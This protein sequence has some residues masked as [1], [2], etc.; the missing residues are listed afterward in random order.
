MRKA[1]SMKYIHLNKRLFS[2]VLICALFLA[3]FCVS[4]APGDLENANNQ[5]D[6]LQDQIDDAKDELDS[7]EEQQDNLQGD[8]KDL[9]NSL[10][11]LANDINKLESQISQKQ[12][13]MELLSIELEETTLLAS[14]QYESMKSR[15]QFMYEYGSISLLEVL[16]ESR[17]FADFLNRTE[18]VSFITSYDREKLNEYQQLVTDISQKKKELEKGE[19]SLLA[20]HDNMKQKQSNV[21]A[22]IQETQTTID[23]T[24]SEISNAEDQLASLSKQLAYWEEVER[25]LEEEK[26]KEDLEKWEEIQGSDKEDFS[27]PY[28]PLEGEAYLLAAIIQ[29]EAE[30]EPYEGKIAVGNVVLN[31]VKSSRF[32]N[33]ITGVIY[34]PKQFSPVASGRLAYR[35]EAGVND[36][37]IRAATEV[38]NGKHI[39]D[40]LFF[41]RNNGSISGTVIG[42]HV[43]Y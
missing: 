6:Q 35:L 36:E 23:K 17:S 41:R 21:T 10:S 4:G 43:F 29:C 27:G 2:L 39:T 31:R 42:N 24:Q 22:L 30:S 5:V 20:M 13:E 19:A 11:T 16:L 15:I 33:T 28:T 40:A 37:C 3:S 38:L 7:F 14:E 34:A 18:Y 1:L 9:N 25:K 12:Q 8:L 26:A 32:P